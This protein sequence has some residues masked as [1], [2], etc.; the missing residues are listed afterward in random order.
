MIRKIILMILL[1]VNSF[2]Y[3]FFIANFGSAALL[4]SVWAIAFYLGIIISA[5]FLYQYV[6]QAARARYL[7]IAVLIISVTSL[8]AFYFRQLLEGIL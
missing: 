4:N 1:V 5:Y 7:S 6:K 2:Y 8:G 3:I